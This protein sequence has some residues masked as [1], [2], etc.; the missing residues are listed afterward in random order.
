MG[1][2]TDTFAAFAASPRERRIC[3]T[4]L[5]SNSCKERNRSSLD[6]KFSSGGKLFGSGNIGG[7]A[8][9]CALA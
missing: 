7:G 4:L 3:M 1:I 8:C 6:V 9:P 2:V 5:R